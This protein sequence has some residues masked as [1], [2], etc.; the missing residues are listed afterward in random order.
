MTWRKVVTMQTTETFTIDAQGK[1]VDQVG[2]VIT[3]YQTFHPSVVI[4]FIQAV[5]TGFLAGLVMFAVA[6]LA[7]WSRPWVYWLTSWVV[8]Q[9]LA[10]IALLQGWRVVIHRL[11]ER[12]NIDLNNDEYIGE[13]PQV[14][15]VEVTQDNGKRVQYADLDI[16]AAALARVAKSVL[17]GG[18]FSEGSLTG[19]AAPLSRSQFRTMRDT[20]LARGWLT[21]K[22]EDS[23]SQGLEVTHA[24]KAVFRSFASMVDTPTLADRTS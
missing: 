23:R 7:G 15:R 24:G 14:V 6:L 16:D 19:Y 10:W 3:H 11:E 5:V 17:S 13:P 9:C 8:I 20:F 1:Q 18:S 12:L 2:H 21:W 22:N 4:P